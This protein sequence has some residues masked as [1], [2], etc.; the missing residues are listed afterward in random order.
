MT[1]E[2]SAC[3]RIL[4]DYQ[5]VK[6]A[7]SHAEGTQQLDLKTFF[8]FNQEMVVTRACSRILLDYQNV[9][10]ACSHATSSAGHESKSLFDFE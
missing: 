4:L 2:M 3:S 8:V 6:S 9:K 7:R 5:H 10:S 1:E